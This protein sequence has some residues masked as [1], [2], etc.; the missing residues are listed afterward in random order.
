VDIAVNREEAARYGL[1]VA[2]V[3][4]AVENAIGGENI[5]TTIMGRERYPVNVRYHRDFRSDL[6]ELGRV[7]VRSMDG[8]QIPLAQLAEVRT[9]PGPAMIRDEDGQ[10]A[11]Y[12]FVDVVG[13]D[14]GSYVAEAKAAVAKGLRMPAG[15]SFKWSGQYEF[16]E[17]VKARLKI[18]VPLTLA[19]IFVLYYFTFG[20]VVETLM[21]ML[22][23]PFAL[24]GAIFFLSPDV[25]L[26]YN[27]SIAVWVGLIALAGVSA[28]TVAIMLA[29][30]DEAWRRRVEAGRMRGPEDLHEAVMEGSVLRVRPMLMTALA[31]IFGLMPVMVSTGA[32][33]DVMKRI[34]A[35]MV[36]GL[37]SAVLL[38]LVLVPV[39]YTIWRGR[40][41]P[42]SE[43]EKTQPD[44]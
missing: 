30:L 5:D 28:E 32:G 31:N 20:S 16:M 42:K 13:R 10:L 44:S 15:Y 7:L 18:F 39:L 14:I 33:A 1:S 4:M 34:A 23:V 29:Y 26:S 40:G 2:E 38:T 41:L 12:I 22:S 36:G 9:A 11:A 6:P 37:A 17:R 25:G 24:I 19:I 3:Q 43:E 8:A 27:M 35:P 21:I